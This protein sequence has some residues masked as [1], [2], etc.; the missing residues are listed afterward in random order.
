MRLFS[1]LLTIHQAKHPNNQGY[2]VETGPDPCVFEADIIVNAA[3]LSATKIASML[4]A[5]NT[6]SNCTTRIP[7]ANMNT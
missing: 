3:G 6:P 2:I 5:N 4:L 7:S 1:F